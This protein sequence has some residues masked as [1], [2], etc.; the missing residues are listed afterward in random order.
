MPELNEKRKLISVKEFAEITGVSR[1]YTY[2]LIKEGKIPHV[3]VGDKI[4]IPRSYLEEL[5]GSAK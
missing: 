2:K 1:W 4:T 3:K 5:L